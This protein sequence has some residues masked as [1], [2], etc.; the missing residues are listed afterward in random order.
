MAKIISKAILKIH[1][2]DFKMVKKMLTLIIPAF[3]Q[4][5]SS[6]VLPRRAQWS[7]PSE[8]MPQAI[9]LLQ[10]KTSYRQ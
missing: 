9:G 8:E 7:K 6:I 2:Q 4:A 3:C 5:I 10:N 1:F